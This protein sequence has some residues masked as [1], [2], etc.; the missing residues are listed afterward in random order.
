[1]SLP[2]VQGGKTPQQ[3]SKF[4]R[5]EGE[6]GGGALTT[7]YTEISDK[8]FHAFL[9]FGGDLV[10]HAENTFTSFIPSLHLPLLQD[11]CCRRATAT[12]LR[13]GRYSE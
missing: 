11:T 13:R 7:E 1:M 5:F 9:V 6:R 10:G 4:R 2:E 3:P 8:N 12:A